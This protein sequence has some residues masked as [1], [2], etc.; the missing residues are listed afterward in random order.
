MIGIATCYGLL[1]LPRMPELKN[2]SR[3][4]WEDDDISVR[5]FQ[6]CLLL[7]PLNRN[8]QVGWL[9]LRKCSKGSETLLSR[10]KRG[11]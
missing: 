9:C 3:E 10:R 1:R 5:P 6:A 8:L 4:G 11:T 2:V 7:H